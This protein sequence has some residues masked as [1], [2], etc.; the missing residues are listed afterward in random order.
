LVYRVQELERVMNGNGLWVGRVALGEILP[1]HNEK[2]LGLIHFIY[3]SYEVCWCHMSV[4]CKVE[5]GD[6]H[7]GMSRGV[8][9]RRLYVGHLIIHWSPTREYRTLVAMRRH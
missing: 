2:Y 7:V 1:G 9:Y 3:M 6:E 5:T 4:A 8:L